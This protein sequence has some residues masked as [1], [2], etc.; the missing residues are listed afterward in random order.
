[1]SSFHAIVKDFKKSVSPLTLWFV[2]DVGR[3]LGEVQC[4]RGRFVRPVLL[5]RKKRKEESKEEDEPCELNAKVRK[6]V[7]SL[8]ASSLERPR[9]V[10]TE[11]ACSI[12][13]RFLGS[14]RGSS[15]E[16]VVDSWGLCEAF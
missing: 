13:T 3:V 9:E 11:A 5:F 15:N 14:V 12:L 6:A 7:S 4:V 8:R 1:M 16:H 10:E 2:W